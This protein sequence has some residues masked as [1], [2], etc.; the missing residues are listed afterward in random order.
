[1][2]F[3]GRI[4]ITKKI[5]CGKGIYTLM[6]SYNCFPQSARRKQQK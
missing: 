3:L 2:L 4:G 1:V 6:F 5:G